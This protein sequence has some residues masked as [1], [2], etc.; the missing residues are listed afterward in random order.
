MTQG[1]MYDAAATM[2]AQ[3]LVAGDGLGQVTSAAARCPRCA[4]S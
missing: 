4:S 1:Q 3:K 2:L